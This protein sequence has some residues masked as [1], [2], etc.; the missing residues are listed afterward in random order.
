MIQR[1]KNNKF[2]VVI[3]REM[4]LVDQN[5]NFLKVMKQRE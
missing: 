1:K 3:E 2:K 5:D 4:K